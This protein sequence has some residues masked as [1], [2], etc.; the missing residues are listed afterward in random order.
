[1][2]LVSLQYRNNMI[3]DALLWFHMNILGYSKWCNSSSLFRMMSKAPMQ[4]HVPY[5]VHLILKYVLITR[6][7]RLMFTENISMSLTV[8]QK[9]PHFESVINWATVNHCKSQ[10]KLYP[11]PP[12]QLSVSLKIII[13]IIAFY[14]VFW[15]H[16]C[17]LTG[18]NFSD[19][20]DLKICGKP[21]HLSTTIKKSIK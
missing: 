3:H 10:F 21:L 2:N 7:F 1:M 5:F 13:I 20:L 19:F 4:M 6:L 16:T 11:P 17:A 15:K 8:T 18:Q 14:W 12:P 9:E